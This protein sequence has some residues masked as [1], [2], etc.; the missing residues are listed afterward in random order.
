MSN[1]LQGAERTV[2]GG[3]KTHDAIGAA[4]HAA[5]FGETPA[6]SRAWKTMRKSSERTIESENHPI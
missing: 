1:H 6:A 4:G 5:D 3:R 2:V